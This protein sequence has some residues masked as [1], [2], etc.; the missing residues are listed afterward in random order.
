MVLG[1]SDIRKAITQN[2]YIETVGKFLSALKDVSKHVVYVPCEVDDPKQIIELD[3]VLNIDKRSK[4]LVV[5]NLRIGFLGLGGAPRH[6]IRRNEPTIYLWNEN[7]PL[8]YEDILKTLRIN[9]EKLKLD[10]PDIMILASHS[11]P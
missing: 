8:I 10:R 2:E 6:S 1:D 7:V 5:N 4:L 3:N 11:P 9:Y